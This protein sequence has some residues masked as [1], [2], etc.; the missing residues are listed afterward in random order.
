VILGAAAL[1]VGGVFILVSAGPAS[2]VMDE[3]PCTASGTFVKDGKTVQASETGVVEVPIKDT[4]NW[5][6]SLNG[7]TGD[8]AY[9][10]EIQVDLPA[11]FPAVKIDDWSGTTD[12]T[13]N[14]DH[15]DYDIP[16]WVPR[17][18]ELEVSG[19]HTQ[20]SVTCKGHVKIKLAGGVFDSVAAPVSVVATV[21]AALA[22]AF[23]ARP[24]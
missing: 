23:A 20:G 13:D 15:K 21:F 9:K 8:V 2:A 1:L 17:N 11:P 7:S 3:G 4:V 19:S 22:L 12:S 5:E 10:G 16:S 14:A 18:V 6:G 24:S